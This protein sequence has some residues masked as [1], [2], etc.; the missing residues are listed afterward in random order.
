MALKEA[1]ICKSYISTAYSM[2]V[3]VLRAAALAGTFFAVTCSASLPV[4]R[5]LNAQLDMVCL[6]LSL[7]TLE[8]LLA[9]LVA[10][11]LLS[12]HTKGLYF[13]LYKKFNH[14]IF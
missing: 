10:T 12:S 1:T 4:F 9:Q 2:A 7:S 3:S 14:G 13:K 11:L 6:T 5:G 8:G